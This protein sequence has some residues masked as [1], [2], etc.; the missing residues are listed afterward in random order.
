MK[1]YYFS[2]G[3]NLAS[4]RLE[5]EDKIPFTM[6]GG[7]SL[8]DWHLIFNKMS[9][10]DR[11]VAVA[12]IDKKPG[13]EVRGVVYQINT[14]DLKTI[15]KYEYAPEEYERID[16]R[17][18]L[19]DNKEEINAIAYKGTLNHVFKKGSE[20]PV[21][22]GYFKWMIHA[23]KEL[24]ADWITRMNPDAQLKKYEN[25]LLNLEEFKNN[26]RK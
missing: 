5:K 25:Y 15:D 16:V 10:Q 12:N 14:K 6:I 7:A 11:L 21:D 4:T 18:K 23:K 9:N 26:E 1:I 17:V 8:P 24:G 19:L 2:Y 13:D 3:S 20:G 22:H